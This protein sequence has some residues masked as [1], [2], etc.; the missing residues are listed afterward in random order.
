M[1]SYDDPECD[2]NGDGAPNFGA[3]GLREDPDA[4]NT[5]A[6]RERLEPGFQ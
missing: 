4:R 5:V 2:Q 1:A 6:P 3:D